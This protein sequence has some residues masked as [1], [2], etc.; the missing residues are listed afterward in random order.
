[1]PEY[2]VSQDNVARVTPETWLGRY[3]LSVRTVRGEDTGLSRGEAEEYLRGQAT[4]NPS[5]AIRRRCWLAME[6]H[7]VTCVLGDADMALD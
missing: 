5:A 6:W 1:M 4:G 2:I 3:W 7:G